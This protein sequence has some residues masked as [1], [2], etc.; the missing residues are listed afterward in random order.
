MQYSAGKFVSDGRYS[1]SAVDQQ[2]G[3]MPMLGAIGGLPEEMDMA[4]KL[5]DQDFAWAKV[6]NGS[7][8]LRQGDHGMEVSALQSKLAQLGYD[9]GQDG[10]FGSGTKSIVV[11]FQNDQALGADGVV[12]PGTAGKIESLL[13]QNSSENSSTDSSPVPN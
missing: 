3:V 5:I 6:L 1:A 12:G 13:S 9:I 8:I 11:Q 10:D 4:P 2:L 7:T